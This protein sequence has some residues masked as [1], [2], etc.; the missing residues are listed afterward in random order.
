[1]FE[2]LSDP[3]K[4]NEITGDET[5]V[6]P[7]KRLMHLVEWMQSEQDNLS[8]SDL[9]DKTWESQGCPSGRCALESGKAELRW[10]AKHIEDSLG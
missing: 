3:N 1:M 2:E 10:W 8:C 9:C 7:L 6:V 4:P 5:I